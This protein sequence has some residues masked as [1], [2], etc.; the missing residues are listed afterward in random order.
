MNPIL[1]VLLI[2]GALAILLLLFWLY[3]IMPRIFHKP[4]MSVLQNWDYAHRGYHE[5]DQSVP[6]NSLAAFS[7]AVENGFGIELDVQLSADG[8]VVVCHDDNLKRMAGVD[9]K[10]RELTYEELCQ[11]PLNN[12][13]ERVPLFSDA[14]KAVGG[15]TPLIVEIKYYGVLEELC[16]KTCD[17]LKNYA[18]VYCIESFSPAVVR[19]FRQNHPEIIRGQLMANFKG[20]GIMNDFTA[21]LARNLFSNFRT[22]P[23]F[24]AYCYQDRGNFSLRV[25]KKLYG[26]QEVSWTLLKQEEMDRVK[27]DGGLCIFQYFDPRRTK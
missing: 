8:K 24:I 2:A 18:G 5:K 10:I 9:K 22:R 3:A 21:F 7:R 26:A 12:T 15:R 19:W 1:I 14:L 20:A 11:I 23:D 16:E 25:S 13:K 4:D 17:I 27:A 6:E